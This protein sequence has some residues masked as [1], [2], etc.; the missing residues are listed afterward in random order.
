VKWIALI[1]LVAATAQAQ[2]A[3]NAPASSVVRVMTAN[4]EDVRAET[5]A[6]PANDRI[7]RFAEVVQRIDPD[8][9]FLNEFAYVDGISTAERFASEFLN[10]DAGTAKKY[11]AFAA[12][13]NTGVPSGHDLDNNGVVGT[14]ED[15]RE[16]GGDCPG[17]GEFPGQYAMALLVRS[18]WTIDRESVRTF[19]NFKWKDMPGALLPPAADGTP[20]AWY[21]AEELGVLPLSSKSH[22]DVPVKLPSGQ[23][24]HMLCSHPTPPVFDGAEDRNGRRNHDEI[25]FWSDYIGG[26]KYI[27][28]DRGIKGGLATGSTF[29]VIGDLNADPHSG[30]TLE[31]PIRKFLL[32]NPLVNGRISPSSRIA[33]PGLDDT[34]TSRFKLRVDYVLPSADCKVVAGAVWRGT[35]DSPAVPAD[36]QPDPEGDYPS[37]H[38]P[39][40][41]DIQ[42]PVAVDS[43]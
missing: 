7:K 34:D 32:R 9:L 40:W 13:S 27:T 8:I 36:A 14:L 24:I 15:P 31:N 4:V 3:G 42:L 21:S 16:Y 18:D 26:E 41:L 29:I 5:V 35:I 43:R 33:M 28:D 17:Y 19:Q 37:D 30:D 25:R 20:G 6:D 38:F 1:A 23:V 10:R 22:W 12:P 39:V 11:V 2:P